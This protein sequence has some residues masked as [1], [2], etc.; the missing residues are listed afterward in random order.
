M[1]YL[2]MLSALAALSSAFVLPPQA[3]PQQGA[4]LSIFLLGSYGCPGSDPL[5]TIPDSFL[6]GG[7]HDFGG[8]LNSTLTTLAKPWYTPQKLTYYYT[9]DCKDDCQ[10]AKDCKKVLSNIDLPF[11]G[12]IKASGQCESA[13]PGKSYKAMR[14]VP[15][16]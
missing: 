3:P 4:D 12:R 14:Y 6:D 2:A 8:G 5:A 1:N 10:S 9:S 7:C 13:A 16:F 11:D 15:S